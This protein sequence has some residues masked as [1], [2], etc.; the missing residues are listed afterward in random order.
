[1]RWISRQW[2]KGLEPNVEKPFWSSEIST[3]A[4][5]GLDGNIPAGCS[6]RP[7]VSPAHPLARRDVPFARAR[8]FRF[9][10]PL[11]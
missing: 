3:A 9:A 1:M 6:K 5:F 10:K 11:F 7:D 4:R 2:Q 8:F